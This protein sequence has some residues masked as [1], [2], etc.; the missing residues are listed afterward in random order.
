MA[1]VPSKGAG[2]G[3][4]L[5]VAGADAREG[6]ATCCGAVV[7]VL[8]GGAQYVTPWWWSLKVLLQVG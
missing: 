2:G 4:G 1:R 6:P 3:E 5:P 7:E 8:T